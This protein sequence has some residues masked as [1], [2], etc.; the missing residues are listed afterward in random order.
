MVFVLRS[1]IATFL[2]NVIDQP[3]YLISEKARFLP[4]RVVVRYD[5]ITVYPAKMAGYLAGGI[6]AWL[7]IEIAL[8]ASL[9]ACA[10][11][12]QSNVPQPLPP[13][14][15]PVVAVFSE[16]DYTPAEAQKIL[17]KY[18]YISCAAPTKY[19]N[20]ALLYYEYN[21]PLISNPFYLTIVDFDQ[22]SDEKRFYI[23]TMA[24]GDVWTT[25]VAA[26]IGSDPTHSGLPT[27]FSNTPGSDDSSLGFYLVS[28]PYDGDNGLS[29][30]LDGLSKT[31]S[32]ARARD[33]VLHGSNY[34]YDSPV[35][36]GRS[37]GCFAVP[38]NQRNYV[39]SALV[40][41]SLLY[42]AS[43]IPSK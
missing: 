42:A 28:E 4:L 33:I 3:T 1:F 21:K 41:G 10:P 35:N 37:D 26:G 30:R 23:I 36:Q 39:V 14:P 13:D 38:M 11:V 6:M 15:K 19:L 2:M 32:N 17:D 22:Y 18:S 24:S 31:N 25:Y 16:P 7:L 34:V 12:D 20:E 40:G 29:L 27:I 43:S 8:S 5:K 9:M